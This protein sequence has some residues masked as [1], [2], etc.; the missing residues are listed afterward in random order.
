MSPTTIEHRVLKLE[1]TVDNHGEDIETIT[2]QKRNLSDD[3]HVKRS[4]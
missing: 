1:L 3:R 4:I 2:T